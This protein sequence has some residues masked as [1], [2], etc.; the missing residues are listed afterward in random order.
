MTANIFGNRFLGKRVPAW[1]NLGTVVEDDIS[2][3]D[4]FSKVGLNYTVQKAPLFAQVELDELTKP[5]YPTKHGM[6][7]PTDKFAIVRDPTPDDNRR[8]IFG[9]CSDDYE[10]VQNSEIAKLLD[11]LSEQWKTETVGAID[12]G[13]TI[14]ITLDAGSASI[15][16]K[17]GKTL[18]NIAKYFLITETKNGGSA[19]KFAF[20]PV[21]VVCQNTLVSGLRAAIITSNLTHRIGLRNEMEWRLKLL[22]D[23]SKAEN[24]VM[25]N[26]QK[27][28]KIVLDSD[29]LVSIIS[30]AYPEPK[31]SAKAELL[32]GYKDPTEELAEYTELLNEL[33]EAQANFE[34]WANRSQI[35]R[36][37]A[38]DLFERFNDEHPAFANTGWAAY[39]AVVE[40]ED[41]RSGRTSMFESALWGARAAAKKRAFAQ[42]LSFVV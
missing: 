21:R 36:D 9:I 7:L 35:F 25:S 39:N 16:A 8:H 27:M 17:N 30:A 42:A 20:T 19:M 37:S 38:T 6:Q 5:G 10:I 26:M 22:A 1:H 15:K 12:Y 40:T 4:A 24:V 2:V 14:F 31:K 33:T 34:Y 32:E 28:A 13:K 3:S 41:Y 18:D 23:M 29:Q 11:P